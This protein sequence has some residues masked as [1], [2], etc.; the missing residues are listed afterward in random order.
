MITVE[1]TPRQQ[2]IPIRA[3]SARARPGK[4][5]RRRGIPASKSVILEVPLQVADDTPDRATDMGGAM[6]EGPRPIDD[7][8]PET[9]SLFP[10]DGPEHG[11]AAP[12]A[13]QTPPPT[14]AEDHSGFATFADEATPPSAIPAD[15]AAG[16]SA[17]VEALDGSVP[18]GRTS[19]S[20]VY[21]AIAGGGLP[22]PGQLIFDRYIVVRK[23]GEGGMG[24]VWLV[25]HQELGNERALKL[26]ASG[27]AMDPQARA[28]FRREAR[29]MGRLSHINAVAVHDFRLARDAAYIEMEYVRGPSLNHLMKPGLLMPLDWTARILDQLCD[30]L[31][32]AHE[33]G[34][35]HRDLKPSNLMLVEGR[36]PGK[37]L[38]K[39]LDFGI[40]KIRDPDDVRTMTGNFIGTAHYSSPEQIRGDEVDGR[41]D[42]YSVGVLLYELLTGYRPF[43]GSIFHL[44]NSHV[45]T[46]PPAFVERNPEV[47]VPAAV[48]RVVMSCLAKEPSAR[49]Q[50][51]RALSEAFQHALAEVEDDEPSV[52][53][54]DPVA[55][56]TS[57]WTGTTQAQ[58]EVTAAQV[59]ESL[60]ELA[61]PADL[62]PVSKPGPPP[63]PPGIGAYPTPYPPGFVVPVQPPR[64]R[65]IVPAALVL[66]AAL[67][68]VAGWFLKGKG[69]LTSVARI[70]E[71]REVWR[72]QGFV[73]EDATVLG[74]PDVLVR[75]VDG[76][77]FGRS[78][79]YYLPVGYEP[80]KES[81][82]EDGWPR[83]LTRTADKVRFLRIAG[84]SKPFT[85]G[86][87]EDL[88]WGAK[89]PNED[90]PPVTLHGFYIQEHEVTNGEM[91]RWIG[92]RRE[93]GN[94][95]RTQYQ[96]LKSKLG[97]LADQH[98]AVLIN[99]ELAGAFAMAHQGKLPTEAQW[100]YT[101]RSR[102]ENFA[103]VWDWNP[104]ANRDLPIRELANI[105]ADQPGDVPTWRCVEIAGE[106]QADRTFQ[107]VRALAGNVQ[108]WTRDRWQAKL[109]TPR[110][111]LVD[112]EDSPGP[113][114]GGNPKIVVRGGSFN[115]RPESRYT[116]FRSNARAQD[117]EP[118]LGFRIVLECPEA[119]RADDIQDDR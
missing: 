89:P 69:P 30:V 25:R 88:K 70:A 28:R 58:S 9:L 115:L 42:L 95:W 92:T 66:A 11:R 100:E 39:V 74:W 105:D 59:P 10:L 107:G 64:N 15:P 111:A 48:E 62:A 71:Q 104:D 116:T 33:Q 110:Q 98:P 67:I 27:I 60:T 50:N 81:D 61:T 84:D 82:L 47:R 114:D 94:A 63:Y 18:R 113:E 2:N 96:E 83:T 55:Q 29:I 117:A 85:W 75:K 3:T 35:T 51:A 56:T 52:T 26:I 80:S 38:L 37:E 32:A 78:G 34:I 119:L 44:T 31:Q 41:S 97:A 22:E 7:P 14:G 19:T 20:G 24:S 12:T 76:A 102:G 77:R 13:E 53:R 1:T 87:V 6:S 54:F 101:A 43:T 79:R 90:G 103:E 5:G 57:P 99:W 36:P 8:K 45:H 21:A 68:I 4:I 49:P 86:R 91:A 46:P 118:D 106:K 112:P 108:E 17:E 16:S 40:A 23:L 73:P 72:L 65:L 109:P 93:F